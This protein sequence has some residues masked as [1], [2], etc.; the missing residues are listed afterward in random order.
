MLRILALL[1]LIP[2]FRFQ[3][4]PQS[5]Q[6]SLPLAQAEQATEGPFTGKTVEPSVFTGS[7]L[8]LPASDERE[9]FQPQ[10]LRYTP[11]QTP[12]GASTII[13]NWDDPVA[14]DEPA[15]GLMPDPL[16]TFSGIENYS[17]P[18]RSWPPDT[19]G[20]VGPDHYVQ[21]VNTSIGIY[22]KTT[23]VL[24]TQ[25]TFNEF[26]PNDGSA[27]AAGHSGDPVVVYDRFA[28]R[29]VI[30]DFKVLDSGPFYECVAVSR[31]SDPVSGGWYYYPIQISAT[32]LN[33]YP[34][35]GV[36]R[37]SYFFTFNM[38]SN[39]GTTWG[40]VQVWALEKARMIAGLPITPVYFSLSAGSGYSSLL[41]AH[42]LTLPPVGAPNYLAAVEQPG[43]V[44]IWEFTPNWSSPGAST[45]TGP[46]ELS[47]APFAAAASIPQ[48]V[49]SILLDSLSYRPM[50]QLIY[51]MVDGVEALWLTHT[52]ASGGGAGM[53]WYEVRQP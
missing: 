17:Q 49:T 15:A 31:T 52:V 45:F 23:G 21:T 8:D 38:F 14:Q 41:P 2:L 10:P 48:P 51:R 39:Y 40:G 50:M 27:C 19:N 30:S 3:L 22:N 47:V 32:A 12:K 26:F 34:K 37:D 33:D 25:I 11:G 43:S 5:A 16:L 20:D 6:A 28:Q 1:L 42:A 44:L 7:L 24:I 4:S 13:L 9:S 53:R 35:L 36:W 18:A 46:T 29:W